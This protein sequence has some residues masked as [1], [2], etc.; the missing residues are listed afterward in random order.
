MKLIV[1]DYQIIKQASLEFKPGLTVIVGP[2]NNG[3]SS[4]IKAMKS[5]IY[6]ESGTTPIRH[7][8]DSYTVAIQNNKHSVIYQKKE[9]N[10]NYVVDGK[11][12]SK[13]GLSTPEEVVNALNIKE[14]VLNG[15]KI[16]LNFWDQ[17]DKPF[18]LDKSG[19]DLF[20]FI[21]DSGDDDRLSSV[22]KSMVSDRQAL[23]REA[24]TIQG[25]IISTEKIIKEQESILEKS[26]PILK[27]ADKVIDAKDNYN[28]YKDL[29][30]LISSY[31][32]YNNSIEDVRNSLLSVEFYFNTY[33][34]CRYLISDKLRDLTAII[35]LVKAFNST[36]LNIHNETELINLEKNKLIPF[37]RFEAKSCIELINSVHRYKD[38]NKT[39]EKASDDILMLQRT[40]PDDKLKN[41][42]FNYLSFKQELNSIEKINS[43]IKYQEDLIGAIKRQEEDVIN[44]KN[45]I[46]VC[47]LCGQKIGGEHV[48]RED[49]S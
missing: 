5:A 29:Q 49:N 1:K 16:Q 9:G 19:G 41:K 17:M 12:F 10:T 38:I 40:I 23:N 13:F 27:L 36:D 44:L 25:S 43:D 8:A 33:N 14:V 48:H 21:V 42:L 11:K 4:L 37:T 7:G 47:P 31:K 6:T 20:K 26:T 46:K 28:T 35:T 45:S 2:S 15:N 18:L 39:I 3:K 24:D 32:S 34:V 22:L 30:H